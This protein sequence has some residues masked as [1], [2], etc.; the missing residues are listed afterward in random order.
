MT[1]GRTHSPRYVVQ[2]AAQVDGVE[3]VFVPLPLVKVLQMFHMK[4]RNYGAMLGPWR[5]LPISIV[6]TTK[7]T[8]QVRG[9]TSKIGSTST[10]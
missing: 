5:A 6:S 2:L 3:S 1:T 10:N 7:S 8:I 4:T 9:T